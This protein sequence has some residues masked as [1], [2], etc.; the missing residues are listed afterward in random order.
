MQRK[1]QEYFNAIQRH[2]IDP[3]QC[4]GVAEHCF[5]AALLIFGAIDGLGRLIH[6]DPKAGA[7]LRFKAY[8]PD[9]MF[10]NS[11]VG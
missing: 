2:V 9:H 5:A 10:C 8:G 11:L 4:N 7:G 3:L 1:T 6:P